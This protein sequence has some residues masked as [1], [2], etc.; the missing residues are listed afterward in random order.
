MEKKVGLMDH[1][2][3]SLGEGIK[4][5]NACRVLTWA[6]CSIN[7]SHHYPIG[8][9]QRRFERSPPSI[10][11][12]ETK[13]PTRPNGVKAEYLSGPMHRVASPDI[14]LLIFIFC[15]AINPFSEI[16]LFVSWASCLSH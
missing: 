13:V 4:R 14:P 8:S 15:T 7:G 5:E 3:H 2:P 11:Q 1:L 12:K 9:L 16:I 6:R 10:T